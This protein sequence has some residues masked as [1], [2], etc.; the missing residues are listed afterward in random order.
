MVTKAK[1][2]KATKTTKKAKA[3]K[4]TAKSENLKDNNVAPDAPLLDLTAAPM[5]KLIRAAKKRGFVTYE[6]INK[7]MPSEEISSEQIED[8]MAMF[9]SMGINVVDEEE[10]EEAGTASKS[11]AVATAKGTA[12]A[13]NSNARAGSDRTD[14][15]VRMYL[16]ASAVFFLCLNSTKQT[17]L[18]H[19]G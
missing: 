10:A 14:D 12:V 1:T 6:D 11:K 8:I 5:K 18:R 19:A 4:T 15:P 13:S 16:R 9:S 3:S 2:T 7:T 17:P